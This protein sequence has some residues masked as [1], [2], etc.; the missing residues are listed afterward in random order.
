[1]KY[2]KKENLSRYGYVWMYTE[3]KALTNQAA[4]D[5]FGTENMD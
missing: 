4:W 1:M 5:F 2:V 3:A